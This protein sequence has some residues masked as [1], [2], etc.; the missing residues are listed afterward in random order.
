VNASTGQSMK[1]VLCH[2]LLPAILPVAFFLI[3]AMPIEPIGCRIRG[4]AAI[5]VALCSG[6]AALGTALIALKGRWR[7]ESGTGWWVISTM[8]LILPVVAMVHL[9]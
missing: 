9:A 6:L 8:V 3:V 7:G 1:R 2:F 4:V 5:S